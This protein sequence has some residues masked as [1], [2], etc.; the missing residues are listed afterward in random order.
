MET[1]ASHVTVGAF[2]IALIAGFFV[3]VLWLSKIDVDSNVTTYRIYFTSSVTGLQQGGPVRFRGIPVGRVTDIRIDPAN[4]ERVQVTVEIPEDVPIKA[5]AVASLQIQ[6]ITGASFVQIGGNTQESPRLRPAEG[7]R[8]AVIPSQQSMIDQVF[9]SA[10]ELLD[11]FLVLADRATQILGPENQESFSRILSDIS[12]VT[13]TIAERSDD[14]D[15]I[16]GDARGTMAD[17]RQAA[18]DLSALSQNL[19]VS[20]RELSDEAGATFATIRGTS[21]GVDEQVQGIGGKLQ[22]SLAQLNAAATNFSQVAERMDNLVGDN[23]QAVSDFANQ[24]LYE[25]TLFLSEARGLVSTLNRLTTRVERN[26]AGFL[27]GDTQRGVEAE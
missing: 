14:I 22:A 27:F 7:Q 4:V 17:L 26:P 25:F 6:G 2:V 13:G 15:G 12:T 10:P 8:Y 9:E 5:D 11:R 21:I 23:E 3:F 19:Q 1:K 20:V 18:G 16:L 24:G